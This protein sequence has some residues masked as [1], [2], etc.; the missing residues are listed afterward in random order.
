MSMRTIQPVLTRTADNYF[1][2]HASVNTKFR[3]ILGA[4]LIYGKIQS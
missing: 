4:L 3:F 2:N 1:D